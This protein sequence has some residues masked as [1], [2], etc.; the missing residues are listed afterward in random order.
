MSPATK[1]IFPLEFTN[2]ISG[3]VGNRQ[4]DGK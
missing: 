1:Y 2:L 4:G 3:F